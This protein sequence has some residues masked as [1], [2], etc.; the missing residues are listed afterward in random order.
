MMMEGFALVLVW[1]LR[2]TYS[3]VIS[4]STVEAFD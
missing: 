3:F 4:G 1:A 2:G